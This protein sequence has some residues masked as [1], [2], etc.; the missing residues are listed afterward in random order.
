MAEVPNADQVSIGKMGRISLESINTLALNAHAFLNI[1][2]SRPSVP[3]GVTGLPEVDPSTRY[4]PFATV[5]LVP[6]GF[7]ESSI[8]AYG[9]GACLVWTII[10]LRS[11]F[12]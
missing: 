9:C 11:R 3:V 4:H 7:H 8:A 6:A 12:S 1:L 10:P 2:I 5:I